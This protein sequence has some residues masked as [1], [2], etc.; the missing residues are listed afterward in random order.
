M[1]HD[2]EDEHETTATGLRV[3]ARGWF[4]AAWQE[5]FYPEDLPED[6][7]LSYY[8]NEFSTVLVP[9]DYWSRY[10]MDAEQLLDDVS[11]DFVFYLECPRDDAELPEFFQHCEMLG[12]QLGGIFVDQAIEFQGVY[13][14]YCR[15][16]DGGCEQIIWQPGNHA[17]SGVAELR[18]HGADL[19]KQRVWLE[20]FRQDSQGELKA[21]LVSEDVAAKQLQELKTLAE[22]LGL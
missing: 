13:P 7:Q 2:S 10:N 21:L 20:Q 19:K 8:A 22:L 6:W 11:E 9:A 1:I 5:S 17:D 14:L 18:L 4:H 12:Q 15:H 3:G 16:E